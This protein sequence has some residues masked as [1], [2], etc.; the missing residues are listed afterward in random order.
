MLFRSDGRWGEWMPAA[1]NAP[2]V[3]DEPTRTVELRIVLTAPPAGPGPE[4]RSVQVVADRI[5]T[6]PRVLTPRLSRRVFAT[7]EGLVG[8]TTANGHRIVPNDQFVALPTRRAL[9]PRGRGD[10]SVR[11]CT[12]ARRCATVPV[13]DV[14]PWNTTDDYWNPPNIRQSW[15][16]LPI[17]LPQAQ[18]AF[19]RRHNA[20][21]DGFG[22]QVK[23]PAGIDL[24]DGTFYGLGLRNNAWV[25]VDYLW[26]A[27]AGAVARA[28]A[29]AGPLPVRSTPA[30]TGQD[31]GVVGDGAQVTLDCQAPGA[32]ISGT[33]GDTNM[34]YRIAPGEFV[35][36]A[37]VTGSAPVPP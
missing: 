21:R 17:G 9:S 26:T 19:E 23:N 22:R 29:P 7:R 32:P 15:K 3:L 24:G 30:T 1:P 12:D 27:R 16:D 2:A 6:A 31:L 25:T 4:V 35:P 36:A 20:G 37:F 11:I 33:Q 28:V 18:A 8:G 13:W 14:G 5:D 10:Y 34:W